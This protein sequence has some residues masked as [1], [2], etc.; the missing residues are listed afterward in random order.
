MAMLNEFLFTKIEEENIGNIWFQQ[1]GAKYPTATLDVLRPVFEHCII[2]RRAVVFLKHF[3]KKKAIC[4]PCI[5]GGNI[6]IFCDSQTTIET[7]RSDVLDFRM[8]I[9]RRLWNSMILLSGQRASSL[10][11]SG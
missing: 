3:P 9:T 7:W 6:I 8:G 2:S 5:S 4:G 11:Y 1:H 10:L